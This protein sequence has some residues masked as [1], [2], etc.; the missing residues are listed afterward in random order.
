MSTLTKKYGLLKEYLK[1]LGKVIVAYSG[2]V[3]SALL[4]KVAYDLLGKNVLAVT[5]DSASVPRREMKEARSIAKS[6]GSRHIE[7]QTEEVENSNYNSNPV[8]RCYYCKFELYTKIIELAKKEEFQYIVNGTN[9]DDLGDFRPGLQAA[10]E[11]KVVSPLKETGFTKQDV[12]DLAQQLGL[13]IWD[14]PAT[15]CLASRVPYGSEVTAEKLKM[16][17]SA[18]N[19]LKDLNIRELRVRHFG[20]TARV[21]VLKKDIPLIHS[22]M[23]QIEKVFNSIGFSEIEVIEF[24][25]GALNKLI[26]NNA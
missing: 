11:F 13:K 20:P 4:L 14:K 8:N 23:P 9:M 16:I 17:E 6:I 21:E 2:G 12:R 24:K 1:N 26:L 7:L 3:D 18:E 15:P 22:K 10:D 25:S 19:Y 5:A